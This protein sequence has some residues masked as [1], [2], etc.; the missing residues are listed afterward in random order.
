MSKTQM[1]GKMEINAHGR[2]VYHPK[3]PKKHR[4]TVSL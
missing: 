1:L 3:K 2:K 4:K